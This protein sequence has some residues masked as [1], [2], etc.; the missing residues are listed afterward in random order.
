[1]RFSL[2]EAGENSKELTRFNAV[3]LSVARLRIFISLLFIPGL[4]FISPRSSFRLFISIS[5]LFGNG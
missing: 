3:L 1:M 5:D 2:T 4:A